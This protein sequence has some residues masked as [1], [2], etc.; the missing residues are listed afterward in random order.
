MFADLHL[1]S[2]YSDGV[3][4]PSEICT[5][6]KKK[7]L[8]LLSITDHDTL[9]GEE[10][11]HASA[12][13]QGLAYL[14]GWEISAFEG[15][16]KIHILGYGCTVGEAY[17]RFMEDSKQ[18]A[19]CRIGENVKALQKQGLEITVED[20][21]A[22]RLREDLPVHVM[23][24]A[25]ALG[26]KL[27]MDESKAYRTY[28]SYG[29]PA[30]SNYGRTTPKQAIDCIHACGGVTSIAHPG[31]I[32][33]D[34]PEKE[35]LLREIVALGAEGIE[36]YYTTHTEEETVGFLS[37]AKEWGLY[38][39]GGSDTHIEEADASGGSFH[40]IGVPTFSPDERFLSRFF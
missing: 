24:L 13:A 10:D 30:Y 23:H 8:S 37:L 14:S 26:K 22:E 38:V 4:T 7:G 12:K 9:A 20:A 21:L 35:K 31:R 3:Y 6:A 18:R 19:L 5:R 2:V 1:H 34:P 32:M 36:C 17:Y 27:G 39:T 29:K 11:K 25:R 28:L 15:S 16:L 33:L 40:R